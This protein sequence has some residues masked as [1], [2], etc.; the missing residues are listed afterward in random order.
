VVLPLSGD[1]HMMWRLEQKKEEY[2]GE[3]V[4]EIVDVCAKARICFA[5]FTCSHRS[6]LAFS[7]DICSFCCNL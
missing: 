5:K 1:E 4:E 2:F 7:D 6:I 3:H